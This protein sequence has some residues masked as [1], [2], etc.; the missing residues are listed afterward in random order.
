MINGTYDL[1]SGSPL[2][3]LTTLT[4]LMVVGLVKVDNSLLFYIEQLKLH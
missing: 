4:R 2:P 3:Q 1:V